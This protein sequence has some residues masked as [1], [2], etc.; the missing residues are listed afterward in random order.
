[1]QFCLV[2]AIKS[3]VAVSAL[4]FS[5]T[6]FSYLVLGSHPAKAQDAAAAPAKNYKDR[7]EYDVYSAVTQATDPAKKLELLNQWQDKYPQS[8]FNQDRLQLFVVTTVQAGQPAKTLDYAGQLLKLDPKNATALYYTSLYGPGVYGAKATPDQLAQ[9]HAAGQGILDNA[10]SVFADK[11][12]PAQVSAADW[13]KQKNVLIATAESALGWEASVKKDYATA[14]KD[15]A[16]SITANPEN[17]QVAYTD[18][19]VLLADKKYQDALFY[20]ARAAAYDGPGALPPA[21]RDQVKAYFTKI[22]GQYHGGADGADAVLAAAKASPKPPP[23]FKIV[24]AGDLANQEAAGLQ[25]KLDKDPALKQWYAV[26]QT[27]VA[28]NGAATFESNVK[29]AQLPGGD[30]KFFKG[31]VISIDPSDKPTKIVAGVFD[32]TKPDATLTF[33]SPVTSP[34]KVGDVLEFSGV[35]ASYTKDPYMI[36]FTNVEGPNIKTTAPAKPKPVRKKK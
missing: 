20:Y 24:S 28:D 33:D 8:D 19:G 2:R 27:L 34:V 12:K 35:A 3:A 15:Y 10:D 7:G 23:D 31:T 25:S 36:T 22:Y 14:E 18:A 4:S 9:V 21:T 26:Q 13:A 32:P 1:M 29:D 11:N 5:F 17:A 16:D 6:S 30:V